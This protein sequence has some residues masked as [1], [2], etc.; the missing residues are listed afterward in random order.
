MKQAIYGLILYVFLILPPVATLM[1]SIMAIHMLMQIP[2]LV[3]SSILMSRFFQVRFRDF[4]E[5]WNS[6]GIP[7]FVLFVFIWT[8][9]LVPRAM[10]EA[11]TIQMVEI[12]KFISLPF[13]AG[14][15]L[16]DSWGKLRK[17]G[18]YIMFIYF[19]ITSLALGWLYIASPEQLCNNYLVVEQIALGWSSAIIGICV[20]LYFVQDIFV[21][22]SE[23]E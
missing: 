4:F 8:Y 17:M 22:E 9:W 23:Y 21:D 13:L 20:L 6:N 12:F 5:S 19:I 11:L 2:L 7:G 14:I 18:K 1:E 16:R 10:D 3:I 15:P